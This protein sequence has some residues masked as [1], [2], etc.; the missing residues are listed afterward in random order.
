MVQLTEDA[1]ALL[2]GEE[3]TSPAVAGGKG[4]ALARLAASF[5]V[6]DFFVIP[7]DAID[8]DGLR[9]EIQLELAATLGELGPG[10]FAV[11]SSGREEDGAGAAHAG[12]FE[13]ELNVPPAGVAA[14]A[15]R[16]WRSGFSETLA[17][18]R[19][20]KGL[21]GAPQPPSVVVQVMVRARV[22]GVAF[23][24]DPVSGDRDIVVISAVEG[25][26]D[27]LV[28]G[29]QDGDSYR[30]DAA[31]KTV[32]ANLVGGKP[33]L[34]EAERAQV[35]AM[36]RR[37]A[38]SFGKPQDIEWA[39]DGKGLH[40]LQSRPITTLPDPPPAKPPALPPKP[41]ASAVP[42]RPP[43]TPSG[44]GG[45]LHVAAS[46][47]PTQTS[48]ILRG[49]PASMA[50][51][52]FQDFLSLTRPGP[53]STPPPAAPLAAEATVAPVTVAPVVA[54]PPRP[55]EP[56]LEAKAPE[57][58]AAAPAPQPAPPVAATPVAEPEP[59]KPREALDRMA[60]A[61]AATAAYVSDNYPPPEV[62][63]APA[64]EPE[65]PKKRSLFARAPKAKP[66]REVVAQQTS[67]PA[68]P[69]LTIW[70]NSNIVESYPGVT[71]P[72]TFSFARYVYSEVY[73]AF[74]RLMG[75]SGRKIQDH[76]A[77]F[78]NMLGRVDGRVYYNLLNWYRALA[79]FPGFKANRAFM[80]GMMGVSEP[81]PQ[82]LADQIAPST[83]NPFV[84][85]A[86][87][88]NF[89]RVGV[90]LIWHQIWIRISIGNFYRRLN[91][92][93][94]TTDAVID[95]MKPVELA[96][97]YRRLE[98]KLLARWDAP[99]VNDFLCMIAFG[100]TQKVMT[101]HAG[102]DG[103]AFL[104]NILIGQGDIIS[105]EPARLIRAMGAMAVDNPRLIERLEAGDVTALAERPALQ[106]SFEAYVAKFGDRCTQELKLESLSLHDDPAQVL[107]A[108]AA[109]ARST[110]PKAAAHP[111]VDLSQQVPELSPKHQLK[112]LIPN[113]WARFW[114]QRLLDWAKARVRDRENLRFERTRLFG[115]VRRIFLAL[116]ARLTDA[117]VLEGKRDV[118][119]LTVDELLGAVEGA[120]IM[121]DLKALET[122]R[123]AERQD[124][125]SRP[126]PPERFSIRGA[127]ITGA[128]QLTAQPAKA[129]APDPLASGGGDAR[130]G[131]A[132]CKGV[133]VAK[134]RVIEDPRIEALAPGE[135]LV[136][137]HTDPGWIAVFANAAGVI[138]ERGSLLSHSAIVAR[139]MGVPCVVALKEATTWLR[140]GDTVRLDGGA[141][142]V[143][144]V[145]G[146]GAGH[147]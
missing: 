116:G 86:D 11:R 64:E 16:V 125:M 39:F 81:L 27:K 109:A 26:A 90:G 70:D 75:V 142:T 134:V 20:A 85:L 22:A 110:P 112:Q 78:E 46:N 42:Q 12:Q 40:M 73:Q 76:R 102:D 84:K 132:C 15:H 124:Q 108:I 137:R 143:E 122:L 33:V 88:I 17:Q 95:L 63:L 44:N 96:A 55:P 18:Y 140:T 61:E 139:E 53:S 144:K 117:G 103:L 91:D 1:R 107:M 65:A 8:E 123:E 71:S 24:A 136:A 7:A 131:L 32:E 34:S 35:A 29:E 77:V 21:S 87:N 68:T 10:P 101:E 67:R 145:A 36:A 80:E 58:L 66:K 119:N 6:P 82:E 43:I 130:K 31:G 141:G 118:F 99:L 115:R 133:V 25:L 9:P 14:A 60:A 121:H 104:S 57:P 4:S 56:A 69:D 28:G 19:R 79:L 126:D 54:P 30:I 146:A 138:A 83:S 37:A 120:G 98:Q 47:K 2:R 62:D 5:P 3:A 97:E 59:P 50:N 48:P 13:T 23:S 147:G 135:I 49:G 41:L 114:A 100:A 92:A 51:N 93:L 105:A 106:A 129:Y 38:F 74:S 45:V 127:H 52:G 113:W 72:L 94:S 89:A 128:A 111:S